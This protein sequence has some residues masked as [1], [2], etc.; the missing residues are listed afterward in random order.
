[1]QRNE[2]VHLHTVE[3]DLDH[4]E[5]G[6]FECECSALAEEANELKLNFT[7]GRCVFFG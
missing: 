7:I 6:S 2:G 1:M 5:T 3:K 4:D